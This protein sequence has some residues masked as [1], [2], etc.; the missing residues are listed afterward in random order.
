MNEAEFN[1]LVELSWQRPLTQAE[2]ASLQGYLAQ[3]TEAQ[4]QWESESAL[5]Q[6]LA[7]LPDVPLSS[8]FTSQ[9][10]QTLELDLA[11][12]ARE[13]PWRWSWGGWPRM[14]WAC[15]LVLVSLLGYGQYRKQ[16]HTRLDRDVATLT[17]AMPSEPR[18][19]QDFENHPPLGSRADV[20]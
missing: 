16:S 4:L 20:G 15:G 14:A 18:V 17:T 12:T 8:N 5:S 3:H 7:D 19:L 9:V 1:E 6:V 13:R 10:L 11:R 2:E